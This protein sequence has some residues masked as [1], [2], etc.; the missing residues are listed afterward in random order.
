MLNLFIITGFKFISLTQS[1]W[2]FFNWRYAMAEVGVQELRAE[3][4][5]SAGTGASRAVRRKG[6]IPAIIYGNKQAPIMVSLKLNEIKKALN[7]GAFLSQVF[8]IEHNG[9]KIR[10]LTR[11]VQFDP[12]NDQPIHVDFQVID[13]ESRVRLMV[14]VEVINEESSPGMKRGGVLNIVRREVEV[15]CPADNIPEKL[16][17]DLD[18][19]EIGTSIHISAVA[20]PQGVSPTIIDRDFTVVTVAGSTASKTETDVNDD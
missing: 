11:E 7:K 17:I 1:D 9:K 6:N 13:S 16:V 20:M 15:F 12:V 14:P 3:V 18:G 10:A 19:V 2:A 8:D 4:R 5:V